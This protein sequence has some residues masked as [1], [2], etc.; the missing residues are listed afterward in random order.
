M[1]IK[2]FNNQIV[3]HR[4]QVL[5]R[6]PKHIP[7]YEVNLKMNHGGRDWQIN[8]VCESLKTVLNTLAKLF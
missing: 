3:S 4:K 5:Y 2:K 8:L 6:I 1:D 7:T